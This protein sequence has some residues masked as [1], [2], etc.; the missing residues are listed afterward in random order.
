[1]AVP[2]ADM[3][4]KVYLAASLIGSWSAS[5]LS[6]GLNWSFAREGAGTGAA[7]AGAGYPPQR[8]AGAAGHFL[9]QFRDFTLLLGDGIEGLDALFGQNCPLSCQS[10]LYR[11]DLLFQAP[12]VRSASRPVQPVW[13]RPERDTASCL[14][15]FGL[16]RIR[17]LQAVF[18]L[19]DLL[20]DHVVEPLDGHHNLT[21]IE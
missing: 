16:D 3:K 12:S 20:D 4:L 2:A 9:G 6:S 5:A 10:L 19:G 13:R 21:L 14:V 8:L 17:F 18:G 15:D 1:M 7:M 11:N